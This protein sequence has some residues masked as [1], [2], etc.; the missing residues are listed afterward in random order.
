MK[1]IFVPVFLG[2]VVDGQKSYMSLKNFQ[3][4]AEH[5]DRVKGALERH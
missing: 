2:I 5:W 1:D 4:D 3:A